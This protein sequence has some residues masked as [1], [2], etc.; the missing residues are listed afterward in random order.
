[1][2]QNVTVNNKPAVLTIK[3][4]RPSI[5]LPKG[6][7]I[8]KGSFLW[9]K[10]PE[11][12]TLSDQVGL[13]NLTINNK[14]ISNPTIK[15]NTLWLS[16][17]VEDKNKPKNIV[18]NVNLQV[19]R[20]VDDNIPLQLKTVIELDISGDQREIVLPYALLDQFIPV[21]LKS[22][23]PA[24]IKP[25]GDLL[26]QARPGHWQIELTARHP[27]PLTELALTIND[28]QWP[29]TE[30]WSFKSRPAQRIV[31][32]ANLSSI[33]SSQ[34][35]APKEWSHLP[36]YLLKQGDK[37]VFNV[38]R[39]G[40][41][42]PE[43]NHLNISRRLWLDFEGSG[44]TVSDKIMGQ[45]TQGWRLDALPETKVGQVKLNDNNQLVTH[46]L[47]QNQKGVEVRKGTVALTADS[48]IEGNISTLNA[49]GW[50]QDFSTVNVEL[51]IPPGWRL[52]AAS[53][54]DNAPDSW[55][56]KWTL[57]DLFLVLIASLAISRLWTLYWGLFALISLSLCWHE[58][59]FPQLIWLS[60]IAVIALINVLPIGKL[61][62]ALIGCR[63]ICWALLLLMVIPFIVQQVRVGLYPQLEH[64]FKQI[65]STS[66][67]SPRL[68][69]MD[70]EKSFLYS[71]EFDGALEESLP[72]KK[73]RSVTLARPLTKK[74]KPKKQ[75][76]TGI[77]PSA[78][79]QTGPG[80]PMWQWTTVNLSWNGSVDSQQ[81]LSLWYLSPKMT[82]L[83]NF[84]RVALV[85]ILSLLVFGLLNRSFK[86]PSRLLSGLLLL[87]FL[88]LPTQDVYAEMPSQQLL[89]QLKSRLLKSPD[90]EPSCALISSMHLAI[91][92]K[93]LT[94][95]LQVHTQQAVAIPL[96]SKLDQWMPNQVL[97]NGS[98][99]KALLRINGVLWVSLEKGLQQVDLIGI[100]STQNKF[101]LPLDLKP[102]RVTAKTEGWIIEGIHKNAQADNQLLFSRVKT[103]QQQMST[104]TFDSSALPTFIQ[105]E[106]TLHFDLDWRV[107]TRIIR[108]AKN[109]SPIVM[110]VPL[111]KGE[112]VITDGI[113]VKNNHVLVNISPRQS[114]LAWESTFKKSA[115]IELIAANTEQYNEVWRADVSPMWHLQTEGISVIHHQ[116]NGQWQPEWRPWANEKVNLT[117]TRPAAVEGATLTIDRSYLQIKP[118]KRSVETELKMHVRSSKG[119]QH[120]ITLPEQVVLQSVKINNV[121]QPIRQ[122]QSHV[123]LPIKPGEQNI[124]LL[125]KQAKEQ[126]SF[127]KTPDIN[128]GVPSV[129]SHINVSLGNDR[130]VLLTLGPTF[131][132]A[133]LFWGTLI[134]TL[135]LSFGL[136]RISFVPLKSWH[137][138]LLLVGLSQVA[139]GIAMCVV[140]WLVMLGIRLKKQPT[141]RTYFNLM[142]LGIGA[143]TLLSLLFLFIA[144]EQGLLGSPD[145]Q[146]V[147]NH[148]S[149]FNLNWYQDRS[150][151]ILPV[152]TVISVPL[153][154]YRVLMLLW[155]LWLAVSL[156]NW[157]K[158]GWG[159]FTSNGLWVEK[160]KDLGGKEKQ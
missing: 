120:T 56:S 99:A 140:A 83:L 54:V 143:L 136:A 130:W 146:I 118:G 67:L 30:I 159:C 47:K 148:S 17:G 122:K 142:Q 100:N 50:E 85:L 7:H 116:D 95:K 43:P 158:W 128:L 78:N 125:W 144:V 152:A 93:T 15:N 21:S 3:S 124:T 121:T 52:L 89:D 20:K 58:P 36:T 91:T 19:F 107:N 156:L 22:S 24:M 62:I 37:I 126:A 39:R 129:N 109:D 40:D 76:N 23:L 113:R 41:P 28:K 63:N 68:R 160:K 34:T 80:L 1:M 141:N 151:E 131:G 65:S 123:T 114:S 139:I 31:E 103:T 51:N 79:I 147:G 10:I 157:L 46:S 150:T 71:Q 9:D 42:D 88:S 96:P 49:V 61:K 14:K 48:R 111:L 45:M 84:I 110:T 5:K 149:A 16:H 57:L 106:R 154:V 81:Q 90:C 70:A 134:V 155:S 72:S 97:V 66:Y 12:L 74:I 4:G 29:Q 27:K 35:N 145:M 112:S 108:L 137:W 26:I 73:R 60:I 127:F 32:I 82:M 94:I 87:P 13:L 138:F 102:H 101:S 55:V 117:I 59:Q 8:I 25:S 38:I 98:Q 132:P 77:D 115:N 69:S 33:D 119:V 75:L 11:N 133:V 44:Y 6:L 2:P 104:Q 135:L 153:M 53:G 105:V 86:F 64:Q 18:N 92:P